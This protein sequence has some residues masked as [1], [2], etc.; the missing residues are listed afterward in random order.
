MKSPKFVILSYPR[1]GSTLLCRA[2]NKHPD[3]SV[4]DEILHPNESNM[5]R[6]REHV[7]YSNLETIKD[8]ADGEFNRI[9]KVPEDF[10]ANAFDHLNGFKILY[11]QILPDSPIWEQ[12]I[13]LD[14]KII[15]LE[16]NLLCSAFSF[17]HCMVS[18][19]WTAFNDQ[20]LPHVN[21]EMNPVWLTDYLEKI[22]NI[23]EG[24]SRKL[25]TLTSMNVKYNDLVKNWNKE[26]SDIQYFLDIKQGTL[27]K[28]TTKRTKM[29]FESLITNYGGIRKHIL[30][31]KWSQ[32]LKKKTIL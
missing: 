22:Q 29:P 27:P 28:I 5:V 13:E 3:L 15:Y 21:F 7:G 2:L 30:K 16:R 6:W 10:L 26:I 32:L 9:K 12:L 23:Q 19:A 8:D 20:Y 4:Q 1:T 25:T 18:G 14:V 17:K 11:V 24:I 31:S